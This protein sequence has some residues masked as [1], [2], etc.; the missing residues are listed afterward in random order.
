MSQENVEIVKE[1]T[2]RFEQGDR[3]SWREYFDPTVVWDT[4]ASNMPGAGVYH[5]HEGVERWFGDW[6]ETW[7]DY[8][9]ANR[10]YIDAGDAVVV[11]FRQSG[12]GRG[13]GVRAARDF[14]VVY[15]LRNRKVARFRLYESRE[16]AL[17]ATGLS[18]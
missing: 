18:E 4:T 1:F 13:S 11:V 10:E 6:L 16:E 2:R 14:F 15:N 12:T 17:E 7:T 8:E 3:D 9:I 5:G